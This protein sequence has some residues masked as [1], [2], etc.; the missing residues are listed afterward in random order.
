MLRAKQNNPPG[1]QHFRQKPGSLNKELELRLLV[2]ASNRRST[3]EAQQ[4]STSTTA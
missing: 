1:S 2:L 3:K 4:D